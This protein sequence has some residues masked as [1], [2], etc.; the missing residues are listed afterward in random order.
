MADSFQEK[1]EQPTEKRLSDARKKGQ[2]AQSPELASSFVILFI[3]V[4]PYAVTARGFGKMFA[5]YA[6]CIANSNIDLD[7]AS[8][9]DAL[10]F[11]AR[12]WFEMVAPVFALLVAIGVFSSLVQT[13]FI[14]SLEPLVPKLET[15]DPFG[16][17][18]K[19]FSL[20]SLFEVLK[21]LVKLG[22]LVYVVYSLVARELPAI[23]SLGSQDTSSI[24]GCIG[25]TCFSLAVKLGVIFLFVAGLDYVRQRWQQKRDLMMTRQEIRE[26]MKEREGS[27]LV[28]SRMRSLQR[29]MARRR[30]IE[31]VKKAELVVTNPTTF[32]V[33][34]MYVAKE[35]PAPRIVAKGGGFVAER[36][37][38]T[39]RRHGVTIIE[40]K[41]VARALFYAVK[42]GDYIPESFYVIVAELLAQVYKQRK[43]VI[44]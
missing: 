43:K 11:A 17:L 37:K 38:E 34:I 25:R 32:A 31:D 4:F 7:A 26:E 14:W 27:P 19:L 41:P 33:A 39:A 1:T 9:T 10:F 36:I 12:Q 2:V 6:H 15:L 21:A 5:L 20:R 16:G 29:E 13:G 22:V 42:I 23:L 28:K 3:S 35:M 24:I 44:L 40:N 18:K 8:A 30:M